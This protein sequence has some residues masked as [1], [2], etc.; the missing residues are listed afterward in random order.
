MSYARINDDGRIIDY[1]ESDS[2]VDAMDEEGRTYVRNEY[3]SYFS[4]PDEIG[5]HV[6]F[7]NEDY[8]IENGL[9]VFD[10]LPESLAAV[11]RSNDMENAPEHMASTDDALCELYET[12]L[13]QSAIIDEQDAAICALYEM[14]IG[15]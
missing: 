13:E 2:D 9:A 3:P 7:C 15:E 5:A 4:N 6:H 1:I 12:T 10:P 14:M 11:E 8:R